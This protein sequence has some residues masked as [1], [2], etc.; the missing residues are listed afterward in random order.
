MFNSTHTLIGLCV[1]RTG[2]DR[3]AP[4]AIWTAAVAA[5][6]PDIDIVTAINGMD[7]YITLHRG[8]T[9]GLI[10]IPLLSL[11]LAAFMYWV[12]GKFLGHFVVALV[13]MAT[14]PLLDFTNTYGI[15]PFYPFSQQWYFGDLLFVIDPYLD[16]LL[17]AGLIVSAY[18]PRHR[19]LVAAISLGLSG[20]YVLA[21]VEL[22]NTALRHLNSSAA[23][24]Q[25]YLRSA[26]SPRMLTPFT[27][28]GI[29]ET[30]NQLLSFEVNVFHGV[31]RE[32]VR[33]TKA[34]PS[35]IT[36]AAEKSRTADAL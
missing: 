14:H 27:W 1:A 11:A 9:H 8:I 15:R 30:N 6:L 35:P 23:T 22:R 28:T 36:S 19:Q 4:Q 26:V 29:V 20:A 3:L 12:T 17:I 32:L 21:H 25:D 16:L 2:L 10:G 7:S 31:G 33:M 5:N 18:V 34:A 13:A 24:A